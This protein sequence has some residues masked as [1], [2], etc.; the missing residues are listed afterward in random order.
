MVRLLLALVLI[1]A[2]GG[3]IEQGDASHVHSSRG[4]GAAWVALAIGGFGTLFPDLTTSRN[5]E[6]DRTVTLMMSLAFLLVGSVLLA[7]YYFDL[8]VVAP[9]SRAGSLPT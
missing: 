4:L 7:S 5:G 2:L 6:D 8:H 1:F 3:C 9:A